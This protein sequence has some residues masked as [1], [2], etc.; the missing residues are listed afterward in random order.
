M[1]WA[2]LFALLLSGCS[3]GPETDLQSIAAARSLAA[4]WAMVNDQAAKGNLTGVYTETMRKDLQQQLQSTQH[5]LMRPDSDYGREI[6][7]LFNEP[8]DASPQALYAR[9]ARLR[10]I[11]DSLESA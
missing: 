3:K 4:E 2:W 9:S 11:E 1:R 5:A 10:Q 8:A 7:Q 6:S